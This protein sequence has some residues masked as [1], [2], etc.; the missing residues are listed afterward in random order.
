MLLELQEHLGNT[1]LLL[2][3]EVSKSRALRKEQNDQLTAS[4]HYEPAREVLRTWQN[5]CMP[6]ARELGGERLKLV[7][8]RFNGGETEERL[9]QAVLGYSRYPYVSNWRRVKTGSK[10]QWKAEAEYVFRNAKNVEQ[11]IRLAELDEEYEQVFQSG[12][13]A[14]VELSSAGKTALRCLALG[15]KVFPCLEDSKQPATQHGLL[16]ATGDADRVVAYWSKVPLAN[17]A[18]RTGQE[19][20]LIVLDVDVDKGGAETLKAL[21]AKFE[22]LPPTL[23]VVTPSGGSHFYFRHPGHEIRNTVDVPGVGLDIRG[24]GGYVVAP[25]SA[26]GERRYEIDDELPVAEVPDWLANGLRQYQVNQ[27]TRGKGVWSETIRRGVSEGARNAEMT[28]LV[29]KLVSSNMSSEQVGIV[30]HSINTSHCRPPLM[31]RE[32]DTLVASVLK[33]HARKAG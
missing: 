20:G 9:K 15:W 25:P 5:L 12:D 24:D 30:A 10:D 28:S 14:G 4:K 29:G 16:D 17:L 22:K 6:S 13:D 2:S 1:Q 21:E 19:S 27:A 18:V 23:T 3:K 26:V 32:I 7:I 31:A 11:G 33:T 8:S